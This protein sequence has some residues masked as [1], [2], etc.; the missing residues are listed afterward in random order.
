MVKTL[1]K[2]MARKKP[3]AEAEGEEAR[4]TKT[5]IKVWEDVA[6]KAKIVAA[7][8]GIDLFDYIDAVLRPVIERDLGK[9]IQD[10]K[11]S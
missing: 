6:R 3:S 8:R 2:P 4:G 1:S 10:E 9:A 11:D 7:F 5:T